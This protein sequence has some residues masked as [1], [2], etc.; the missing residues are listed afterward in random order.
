MKYTLSLAVLALINNASAL[1]LRDDDVGD[2]WSDESQEADTLN[3]I[4]AAEKAHGKSLDASIASDNM[5]QILSQ[6]SSVK[7]DNNDDFIKL[8]KRTFDNA[9]VQINSELRFSEYPEARPIGEIMAQIGGEWLGGSDDQDDVFQTLAS[10]KSAEIQHGKSYA[11]P[12]MSSEIYN[13]TGNKVENILAEDRRITHQ[14][15]AAADA[16]DDDEKF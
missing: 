5:Q 2:L 11:L 8:D 4:K 7:F 9:N 10:V 16:D 12:E 6:K 15:L 1:R 3:S 13:K 14:M